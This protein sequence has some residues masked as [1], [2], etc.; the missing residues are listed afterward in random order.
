MKALL[1]NSLTCRVEVRVKE[2]GRSQTVWVELFFF[3]F[4][5]ERIDVDL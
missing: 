2:T 3:F 4:L 5:E 1:S